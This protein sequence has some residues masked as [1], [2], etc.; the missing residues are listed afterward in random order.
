MRKTLWSPAEDEMLKRCVE[1]YGTRNWKEIANRT[2]ESLLS[3]L[4]DT[5]VIL[6]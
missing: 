2:G 3:R 6:L 5:E 4:I 1:R